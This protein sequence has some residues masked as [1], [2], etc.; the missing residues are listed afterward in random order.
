[1]GLRPKNASL[2]RARAVRLAGLLF[3]GLLAL[4]LSGQAGAGDLASFRVSQA[5]MQLPQI[6]VY[7]EAL[8]SDGIPCLYLPQENLRATL[9]AHPAA[10]QDLQSFGAAGEGVA[11]IF[12][13]DI[14]KSLKQ[15]QFSQMQKVLNTWISALTEKDRAA[16][17]TFGDQVRTV[18]DF[19]ADK[20][21]LKTAAAGLRPTDNFTRL[22]EGLVRAEELGLG[23]LE[24]EIPGRRAILILSDGEDDYPGGLTRQM[25]LDKLRVNP[26]PIYAI[27]FSNLK[28]VEKERHL[29]SLG[30]FAVTSGGSFLRV[31]EPDFDQACARMWQRIRNVWVARLHCDACQGD[32]TIAR[33][34]VTLV[35]GGKKMSEGLDLRLLAAA[36]PKPVEPVPAAP[37]AGGK[38]VA[39]AATQAGPDWLPILAGLV[40]LALLVG[41]GLWWWR[42]QK[43]P[44]PPR[45]GKRLRFTQIRGEALGE[46]VEVSLYDRLVLGRDAGCDITLDDKRASRLHCELTLKKGEIYIRDLDSKNGTLVNGVPITGAVKLETD[47]TILLGNSELRLSVLPD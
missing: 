16:L 8:T 31:D 1:M 11:Y 10:V 15:K 20:E 41:G 39:A 14:S 32:G 46:P 24:A 25:V 5:V 12:L 37:E 3:V 42:L 19:T 22:H 30:E 45:Y 13:V 23:R 36:D 28:G 33:L 26:V 21:A 6:T 18:Q 17:L 44:P 29:K 2:R 34:Q 35:Q 47:D 43:L 4:A 9:G 7:L 27:G 40:V 38:T